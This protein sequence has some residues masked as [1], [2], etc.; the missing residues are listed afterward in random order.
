MIKV[1]YYDQNYTNLVTS[2]V[3]TVVKVFDCG[4]KGPRF[5]SPFLFLSLLAPLLHLTY[6]AGAVDDKDLSVS[7]NPP[8]ESWENS[9]VH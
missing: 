8:W 4:A 2:S 3:N 9:V 6:G 7:S 5:K 1:K